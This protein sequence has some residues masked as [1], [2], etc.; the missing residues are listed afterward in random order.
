MSRR[1][2][3]KPDLRL[4][5]ECLHWTGPGK[6]GAVVPCCQ[7]YPK[8]LQA[9]SGGAR[10]RKRESSKIVQSEIRKETEVYS[11]CN[12]LVCWCVCLTGLN[13][14]LAMFPC[15]DATFV[16]LLLRA[17]AEHR[18]IQQTLQGALSTVVI[19]GNLVWP[20]VSTT[21][22]LER[23]R[24]KDWLMTLDAFNINFTCF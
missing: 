8:N 20:L 24:N 10:Q 9:S 22:N 11:D 1:C 6:Y 19:F 16:L 7:F 13:K 14:T 5:A 12:V 15:Q 2:C 23:F 4:T 17:L 21:G 18:V 3:K